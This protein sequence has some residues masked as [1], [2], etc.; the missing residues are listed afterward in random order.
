MPRPWFKRH[1][2]ASARAWVSS[3]GK[4]STRQSRRTGVTVRRPSAVE[5]AHCGRQFHGVEVDFQRRRRHREALSAGSGVRPVADAEQEGVPVTGVDARRHVLSQPTPAP[6][7]TATTA[8]P[9]PGSCRLTVHGRAAAP[10]PRLVTT[11]LRNSRWPKPSSVRPHHR[12]LDTRSSTSAPGHGPAPSSTAPPVTGSP[13][14]PA[15][16]LRRHAAAQART[17]Y[18]QVEP[19]DQ[20]RE[21]RG[22]LAPWGGDERKPFEVDTQLS[23]SCH[24]D[25][26]HAGDRCPRSFPCRLSEQ[27]QHQGGRARDRHSTA[28]PQPRPAS[29]W[30]APTPAEGNRRT[31]RYPA[32]A[33]RAERP[34]AHQE[35]PRARRLP[36][37]PPLRSSSTTNTRRRRPRGKPRATEP[38][39]LTPPRP[40]AAAH[41]TRTHTSCH[42]QGDDQRKKGKAIQLPTRKSVIIAATASEL[43]CR[44]IGDTPAEKHRSRSES[45]GGHT[46]GD[47]RRLRGGSEELVRDAG[48]G[49][50]GDVLGV[51]LVDHSGSLALINR[52]T[53]RSKKSP[54]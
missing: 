16:Q 6:A 13:G 4:A 10:R 24:T 30:P 52:V 18:D 46:R 20:R 53:I 15:R 26:G 12:R 14:Q 8:P 1:W 31:P 39:N 45:A 9:E 33:R 2:T 35:S 11:T 54:K 37:A 5:S 7:S 47:H 25:V 44:A 22:Y 41:G 27:R 19:V 48:H 23:S 40:L 17:E 43:R 42:E 21:H 29:A 28:T 36:P 3:P 50:L 34:S 32:P 51:D 38:V 49:Q